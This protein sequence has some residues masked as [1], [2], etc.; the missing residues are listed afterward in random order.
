MIREYAMLPEL[1]DL[2]H[3]ERPDA[4]FVVGELF[5]DL[6]QSG[7]LRVD[8]EG[9]W[10][11]EVKE[12]LRETKPGLLQKHL[13]KSVFGPSGGCLVPLGRLGASAE[14]G[15]TPDW[16]GFFRQSWSC[17]A[18]KG[19]VGVSDGENGSPAVLHYRQLQD[20]DWWADRCDS[21]Q[22]KQSVAGYWSLIESILHTTPYLVFVDP[23]FAPG[24]SYYDGFPKL[25]QKIA[26]AN[27]CMEIVIH[28]TFKEEPEWHRLD[29]LKHMSAGFKNGLKVVIWNRF[30]LAGIKTER[31]LLTASKSFSLTHAFATQGGVSTVSL[32][33]NQHRSEVDSF[34]ARNR[35]ARTLYRHYH[36][37]GPS[38]PQRFLDVSSPLFQ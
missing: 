10:I 30:D 1:L 13:F 12:Y 3:P 18:F 19:V 25:M 2:S 7:M 28:T 16:M 34:L 11:E 8:E 5:R 24:E 38:E 37:S 26:H 14:Q 29:V 22:I 27:P 31:Y 21:W 4:Q 9:K 17:K 20:A 6:M 35:S 32:I 33:R 36:Q 15:I 23:H